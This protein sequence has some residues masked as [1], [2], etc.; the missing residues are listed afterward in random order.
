MDKQTTIN[1]QEAPA[2]ALPTH[3]AGPLQQPAVQDVR[4]W[5]THCR[6]SLGLNQPAHVSTGTSR[7][8][9]SLWPTSSESILPAHRSMMISILNSICP[10]CQKSHFVLVSR[11]CT[12][13]VQTSETD[14]KMAIKTTREANQ[15]SHFFQLI[16]QLDQAPQLGFYDTKQE[17]FKIHA[18]GGLGISQSHCG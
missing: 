5:I 8:D 11:S 15:P 7:T 10:L 4:P 1:V 16:G 18:Q 9:L 13:P 12:P 2:L 17:V 3:S 6:P 14:R